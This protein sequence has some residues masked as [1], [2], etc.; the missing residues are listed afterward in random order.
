MLNA[1]KNYNKRVEKYS[2]VLWRDFALYKK[3]EGKDA[4]LVKLINKRLNY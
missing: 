1:Q 2:F 3:E 4:V